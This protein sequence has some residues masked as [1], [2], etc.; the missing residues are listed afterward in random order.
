MG[1]ET[2]L[3]R[4]S[5]T[6]PK[7]LPITT[8]S[9]SGP[10][11]IS[12]DRRS[13]EAKLS[14]AASLPQEEILQPQKDSAAP[15]GSC[16]PARGKGRCR[17]QLTFK[18]EISSLKVEISNAPETCQPVCEAEPATPK[19]R[20]AQTQWEDPSHI[21]HMYCSIT[22]S[23]KVD[24]ATQCEAEMGPT[25]TSITVIDDARSR[26]YTGVLRVQFFTLVTV[27]L[28]FSKPSITLPVVDQILMTL[29][30]LKLNLILGDI[31]HRFNVS[32]SMASIVIRH[33]ID[34]MGE[35]FKVLIPWL[36]RE[37]I[38]A[39][40]PFSFQ[41]NY[42]RTICIIDCAESA[43]QRATNHDSRSDTFSQYKSRNT[44]KYL[45]AVAPNGL[46]MFISDAYAGRSSDKFITM[47]S[48]FLDYLR[49]GDEVMADRGFTIRDLLDERRVSLNI[50]AFTYRRNQLTNEETA[51]TRRVP[52]VRIHVERAIQ[53]LKVFKILSQTVPISMALKLDNI[54]TSCAGLVNLKS[55]LI[56]E[57]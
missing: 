24:K 47:D 42:P 13:S 9:L 48:G 32:T 8:V 57:V 28:P 17:R 45:V 6:T 36:P 46:I 38:R 44:V 50:P 51:R 11:W 14:A 19:F 2:V 43:M 54:L 30:K 41:R 29:M 37:T 20:D 10:I 1:S 27:L 34:V 40:M 33:W 23:V 31:A 53:R 12:R 21:D 55:P 16:V 25:V 5:W 7:I 3:Y 39:T 49:A 56:S 15:G 26:L 22:Q 35:Q 4:S 18:L 52:N